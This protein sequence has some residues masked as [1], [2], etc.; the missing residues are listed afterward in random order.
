MP[1][2][3]PSAPADTAMQ[4]DPALRDGGTVPTL[5]RGPGASRILPSRPLRSLAEHLDHFGP[6]PAATGTRQRSALL[7][8]VEASGL[9][10]RGGAGFST[11]VKLRAVAAGRRAVVVANGTE[12]E[13][14]SAKD[15]VLLAAAPHLVLDGVVTAAEAV[16]ATEAIVCIERTAVAAAG[17]VERAIRERQAA[18]VDRVDIRL[19]AT[20]D[21]YVAGEA[22]ALVHWLD[23]GEAKPTFAL[24]H[25][26]DK[27][28]GGRPTLVDN[29]ETLAHLALIARRG[30]GWFRSLGTDRD[31]GSALVTIIGKISPAVV[32]E[33]PLGT[34]LPAALAAAGI[35]L[36][37]V[38]AV[39]VGGYF[40]TWIPA[41]LAAGLTLDSA[42]LA[43]VGGSFGC[44]LLAALPAGTCG[45][46]EAARVTRWLAAQSAGQCGPCVLGLP[47]IADAMATVAAGDR[48]GRAEADLRRWLRLVDGRGACKHPDGAARFVASALWAFQHDLG[49]HRAQGP[50][51]DRAP[52]LPTP[53]TGGWR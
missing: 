11:A 45:L 39:L 10:G 36:R 31:P 41:S 2:L 46:T 23:G 34:P 21:R 52:L 8:E 27:G 28:L 22:T 32:C 17:I 44:G 5:V 25:L 53:R 6:R 26:A 47:A 20:P 18:G 7:D 51:P 16:G 9:R 1:T 19:A 30:G 15:K 35:D 40:G 3:A 24:H 43:T 42:S 49:R 29:V 33:L 50:C 4:P 37:A 13:P 12:G 38:E 14:A 48:D